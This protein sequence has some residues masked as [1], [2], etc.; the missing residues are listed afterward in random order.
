MPNQKINIFLR[1]FNGFLC[2]FVFLEQE[3]IANCHVVGNKN[4]CH[5]SSIAKFWGVG[6]FK[7]PVFFSY[8]HLLVQLITLKRT[9]EEVGR[10]ALLTNQFFY[11]AQWPCL[12][13]I[14]FLSFQR[15]PSV[16][17]QFEPLYYWGYTLFRSRIKSN[18]IL[19]MYLGSDE[20]N[21]RATL[22]HTDEDNNFAAYYPNPRSL[23]IVT[24]VKLP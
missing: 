8:I 12:I 10:G 24:K 23:F 22:L 17:T 14:P 2:S 16:Y 9:E 18:A 21:S 5:F 7:F 19:G 20:T 3:K 11:G 4:T 15:F 13:V 1:G 6:V